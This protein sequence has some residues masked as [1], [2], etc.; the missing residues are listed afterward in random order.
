V[1]LTG[2][3][4]VARQEQGTLFIRD[5]GAERF[6]LAKGPL[7]RARLL[8]LTPQRWTLL[9]IMHHIVCDGWSLMVLVRELSVIYAALTRASPCPLPSAQIQYADYTLWQRSWLVAETQQRLVSYWQ[10]ALAGMQPL[11]LPTDHAR[12]AVQSFR[13]SVVPWM[14]PKDLYAKLLVLARAN[15]VTTFMVLLSA[16]QALLSRWTGQ[17]DIVIGTPIAGRTHQRTEGLIGLLINMLALRTDVSG[18]PSFRELL[19]RVKEVSLG[20]YAHQDLPF[21]KVVEVIQPRRDLSRHPLFQVNL[22]LQNMPHAW[23]EL[24]ELKATPLQREHVGATFDLSFELIETSGGVTGCVRYAT[25]LFL[26]RTIDRL[27]QQLQRL[28][29]GVLTNPDC[30]ISELTL[31]PAA[32]HQFMEISRARVHTADEQRE[33]GVI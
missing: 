5:A 21:E 24:P 29:E 28:L 7:F 6:D 12:P 13:G 10:Q 22:T 18:D 9:L 11:D 26:P 14:L 2:L 16:V 32:V 19:A 4:E 17:Q 23:L 15:G 8:Q 1:D 31:A 3:S 33:Q 30:P 25:D 20:A 27:C